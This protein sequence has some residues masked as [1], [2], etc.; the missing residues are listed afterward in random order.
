M[1]VDRR[2]L[3]AVFARLLGVHGPQGWWPGESRFEIIVG[4]LL[5]QRTNWRNAERALARLRA[6]GVLAQEA[7]ATL[8]PD[9]L[10]ELVRPAGFYRQKAARLGALSRWLVD[11]GGCDALAALD[12]AT[13]RAA[14]L[15]RPGVG[16]ETAD[17]IVLYA[18]ERPSFVVDAYA[19]RLFARLGLVRGDEPYEVLRGAL[20]AA[21]A[22]D[23]A[24]YNEFHALIVAHG[25][26]R[27]GTRP[28]CDGCT[29][30]AGCAHARRAR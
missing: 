23:S 1:V 8:A 7:L 27:C 14:W 28:R 11:Q 24:Y 17:A 4:A 12:D 6:A 20:E 22:A 19:R 9:A 3:E 2:A 26:A 16:P 21:L 13:L 18:Y 29:L 10:A 15:G 5:I 25:K 30:A